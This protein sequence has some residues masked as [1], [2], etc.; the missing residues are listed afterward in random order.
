MVV[1]TDGHGVTPEQPPVYP[2]LWA[3]TPENSRAPGW[4]EVV[5]MHRG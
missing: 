4:G 3:Q 5:R 1:M 2:V